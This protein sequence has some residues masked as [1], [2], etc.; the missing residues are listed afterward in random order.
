M[1]GT[2]RGSVIGAG[3]ASLV[4]LSGCAGDG[5]SLPKLAD[6][7]PFAEKEVPL[8]GKRIAVM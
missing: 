2:R 1:R 4:L 5:P 3:L 7:N 8:P 6:L